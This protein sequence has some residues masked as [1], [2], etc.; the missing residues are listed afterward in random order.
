MY[1]AM[2]GSDQFC[3]VLQLG[4]THLDHMLE[5]FALL[6]EGC[7][8]LLQTGHELEVFEAEGHVDGAGAEPKAR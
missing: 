3:S 1:S 6:V 8:H 5:L 7:N 2:M 4:A